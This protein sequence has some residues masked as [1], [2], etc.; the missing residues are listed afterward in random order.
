MIFIPEEF[1]KTYLE[2]KDDIKIFK[3]RKKLEKRIKKLEKYIERNKVCLDVLS[4]ESQLVVA[5]QE[6]NYVNHVF[7]EDEYE[8]LKEDF[9]YIYEVIEL[10]NSKMAYEI[11][12]K[13]KLR[14]H[15]KLS[16]LREKIG[17]DPYCKENYLLIKSKDVSSYTKEDIRT[18]I[19]YIYNQ[20]FEGYDSYVANIESGMIVE[21]LERYLE[22]SG[23]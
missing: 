3:L 13:K 21:L 10:I 14:Y 15:P 20:D 23:Y 8:I 16:E 18:R 9:E 22:L 6:Y 11:V 5:R 19:S 12:D 2:G 1:Y 4:Y 17:R 7:C